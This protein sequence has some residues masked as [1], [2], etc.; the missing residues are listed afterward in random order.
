MMESQ[1]VARKATLQRANPTNGSPTMS[2]KLRGGTYWIDAT[3]NGKRLRESLKTSDPVA[4]Q[5]AYDRKKGDAWRTGVLRE[6]PKK[7]LNDAF[8]MWVRDKAGKRSLDDDKAKIV[9]FK[10]L[11][12][13]QLADLTLE[14]V[15]DAMPL[16]VAPSTRNRYRAVIRGVLRRAALK[17]NWLDKPLAF[18]QED[19]DNDDTGQFATREQAQ[20]L[21][22]ELPERVRLQAAFALMTGLRRS[23]VFDLE[24]PQVNLCARNVTISAKLAKG[25]RA[26]TIP[27]NSTAI[28]LLESLPHR[29]GRVFNDAYRVHPETWVAA[30][31]RAGLP[32]GF[33][34]H[35]LRH[36]WA[37]WQVQA[38]TP[39]QV[40]Q[41]L[42]GWRTFQMVLRYAR[43]AP[44]HLEDAAERVANHLNVTA[45]S[46]I[47]VTP[48]LPA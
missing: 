31:Q 2:L 47:S 25:K 26:F 22:E 43:F 8:A 18:D 34:F 19:E 14:Q 27:L 44:V 30:C 7:T 11:G 48:V 29:T 15:E 6:R 46:H 40:L 12:N 38:G 10:K 33:R 3:I 41:Q 42:G 17:Y 9:Y 23:N 24:W 37:S 45:S 28:A 32:E 4:A 1:R 36:T 16:D 20:R 35:D 21:L 5:E 13:V 39:L